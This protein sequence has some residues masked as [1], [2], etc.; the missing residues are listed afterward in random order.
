MNSLAWNAVLLGWK[1]IMILLVYSVLLI[2]LFAVRREMARKS[3]ARR[4]NASLAAGK[5]QVVQP[6]S[7]RKLYPGSILA[8]HTVNHL[9]AA[10]DNDIILDGT[11]ISGHHARLKWDGA[12]WWVEDLG[13][14]NGTYVAG[15]ACLKHTPLA[16]Q[17]RVPLQLGDVIFELVETE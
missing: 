14:R 1:W 6:G 7:A 2:L 8:L 12:T 16:L 15:K 5:L 10:A 13:S 3:P 11:Y 17:P 4:Q 9:G